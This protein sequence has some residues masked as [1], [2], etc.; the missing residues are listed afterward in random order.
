MSAVRKYTMTIGGFDPSGG[1]GLIADVKTFEQHA[2][3]GLSVNT[4]NTLQTEK[5]LHSI[6]WTPLEE[7]I[8]AINILLSAYPV[9]VIKTGIMPSLAFLSSVVTYIHKRNPEIKI[10]C[11]P[12][13]RTSSGFDLMDVDQ[14][15]KLRS[16]LEKIFLLTPNV[17]EVRVLTGVPVAEEGAR[18]LAERCNVLLKGGHH[19]TLPG[20]DQLFY[21]NQRVAQFLPTASRVFQKHG[22]GCVL[23]A[24]IAANLTLGFSL[25]DA[26]REAK[27]YVETFLNS[28]PTLLGYH[29]A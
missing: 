20:V 22:S 23:S 13:I 28:N 11:D 4:A 5:I 25:E 9:T 10:V 3:Y 14:K 17:E 15:E 18:Q 26:C 19:D 12:V 21:S 27:R 29:Y 1:A 6:R 16:I 8:A 24:A 7:V 2:V